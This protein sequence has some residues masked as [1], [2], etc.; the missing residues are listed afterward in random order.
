MRAQSEETEPKIS[1]MPN[2]IPFLNVTFEKSRFVFEWLNHSFEIAIY[3]SSYEEFELELEENK[4]KLKVK[5]ENDTE[6]EREV[7]YENVILPSTN[8]ITWGI[9]FPSIPEEIADNVEYLV[10]KIEGA[11]FDIDEIELEEIDSFVDLGYNITRFHLPGN[12]VLTYE[13]LWLYDFIVSHPNKYETVVKGVKGKTVWNLDPI[14]YS[15]PIITVT[16]FTSG[17]PCSFWDVWNASYI[18]GWNVSSQTCENSTTGLG[19]QNHQFLF[20]CTIQIGDGET[21]T[22]FADTRKQVYFMDLGEIYGVKFIHVKNNADFT[23]GIL[24]DETA[25]TTSGGCSIFTD[26]PY[27]TYGSIIYSDDGSNTN[28]YGSTFSSHVNIAYSLGVSSRPGKM[29]NCI[30]VNTVPSGDIDAY[31]I[32]IMKAQY[33]IVYLTEGTFEKLTIS[34]CLRGIYY[35][36]SYV[37]TYTNLVLRSNTHAF[38]VNSLTAE[39]NLINPDIDLWNFYWQG[40]STGKIFRQYTFDLTVTYPNGTGIENANVTVKHYGQGETQDFSELTDSDGKIS[41][42]TLSMGFYNQTGA[43][44]IYSYNPYHIEITNVTDYQDY[45]GNFTLD[46]KTEWTLCICPKSYNWFGVTIIIG[47]LACFMFVIVLTA[48]K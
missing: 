48:K 23:L 45:S 3:L 19:L 12:L 37:R 20:N 33:G 10:W 25:K 31:N 13:D 28:L 24:E 4:I 6:I 9:N 16:G 34:D 7:E 38:Y 32:Q 18:N 15:M 11:S 2:V 46:E 8:N 17:D 39:E 36:S 21:P 35:Y 14:T 43:D 26:Y 42:K 27:T 41:Q 1:F 30:F 47:L 5:L 22:Y 40:V 44:T 29:Y